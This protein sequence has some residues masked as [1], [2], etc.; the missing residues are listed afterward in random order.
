M[1][2]YRAIRA[3][4]P[5]DNLRING[6]RRAQT[7]RFNTFYNRLRRLTYQLH[8][9]ATVISGSL[10]APCIDTLLPF[11]GA[12]PLS[13]QCKRCTLNTNFEP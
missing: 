7:C 9:I 3:V 2:E 11:T 8:R 5:H 13:S 1:A 6:E 10:G 4:I 12:I